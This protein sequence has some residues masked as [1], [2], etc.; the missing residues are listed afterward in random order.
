[1][2]RS[3]ENDRSF[4]APPTIP[5][6]VA[7]AILQSAVNEF[8]ERGFHGASLRQLAL[9]AG[10]TLSNIYNYFPG[11]Q[12]ILLGVLREAVAAQRAMVEAALAEA[13]DSVA[14][15]F[16]DA[17]GAF[18]RYYVDHR[19]ISIVATSEFRYLEGDYRREI[20]A[21]RDRT[22][23]IFTRLLDE[24]IANRTFHTPYPHEATLAVLTM[25]GAVAAWY[26]PGGALTPDEVARHYGRLSLALVEGPVE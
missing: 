15:R 5:S 6:E 12:E 8:S 3:M 21:D 26:R 17:V 10:V 16:V 1:M 20:V 24:G 11:K 4:I 13:G 9:G 7:Q 2:F 18:V 25:C 14:D 19:Q 23:A 22:Q